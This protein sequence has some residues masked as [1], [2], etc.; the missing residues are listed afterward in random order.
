[1]LLWDGVLGQVRGWG[2]MSA[3]HTSALP[4]VGLPGLRLGGASC[5]SAGVMSLAMEPAEALA[6]WWQ[7]QPFPSAALGC[8]CPCIPLPCRE[9]ELFPLW[10][11][12]SKLTPAAFPSSRRAKM[13]P[14]STKQQ[15]SAEA[16]ESE[17]RKRK[18]RE[19]FSSPTSEHLAANSVHTADGTPGMTACL[20]PAWC[21][22]AGHSS[23]RAAPQL[24][25]ACWSPRLPGALPDPPSSADL[26]A[27]LLATHGES[28]L[29]VPG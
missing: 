14:G 25:S 4:E 18:W 26:P 2:H 3:L 17:H 28:G 24:P 20:H 12:K 27:G 23:T 1:M 9:L 11:G 29:V 22:R 15:W 19:S 21:G 8:G 7:F 10:S 13:E 16:R 5:L 6:C